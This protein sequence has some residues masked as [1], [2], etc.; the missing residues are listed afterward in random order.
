ML[1][2]G[3][4]TKPQLF[5][6]KPGFGPDANLFCP[7][8][9]LVAGYLHYQPHLRDQLDI[10]HI[11][12]ERPRP[13]LVALLGEA[14][15]NSPVLVFGPGETPEG[16]ALSAATGRAYINDGKQICTWLGRRFGALTPS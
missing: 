4:V 2:K 7:D 9:A 10:R 15:Q 16:V 13:A 5:L 1:T 8:C 11:G 12:F 6:L 14:L 3:A